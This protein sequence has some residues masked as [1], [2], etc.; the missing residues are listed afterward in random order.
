VHVLGP[1]CLDLVFSGLTAAPRPGAEV[2]ASQLGIAPGGMAN[3]AVALARLGA[4][5]GLSAVFADDPFG[6][7]LWAS[8]ADEGIDLTCSALVPGWNTPVT[9][10]VA[11]GRER[12]MVTYEED[13][14]VALRDLLPESYRAAALVVSLGA[15]DLGWLA[16]LHRFAPLVFAD[17]A[18]DEEARAPFAD[19]GARL[20]HVDVFLPNA[21]E[22]LA[23]T[24]ASS[25]A[26][27]AAQLAS[28]GP[29][30]VVKEGAA[31]S[32]AY[33]AG[34]DAPCSAPS[35]TVDARDT[36]GAGDIFDAGFVYG[37]LAE[38]PLAH[39]L[40]F[41][42]LCAAE[43]VKL[44][45]GSLAAP[46]WRD[47]AAFWRGLDDPVL[48]HDYRFLD[49]VMI[50]ARAGHDCRRSF[51]ALSGPVLARTGPGGVRG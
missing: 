49:D 18:L 8:L 3:V 33:S 2:F 23:L 30:V 32:L 5:V 21:A 11:V 41:A 45:G 28:H 9:S 42:N 39:R 4:D 27:A 12:G 16:G 6:Q 24:G 47:L 20:A 26:E 17:V 37:S 29:M 46:C 40:R 50:E 44:V 15:G 38:W 35:I 31:G 22:A 1:V 43:S 13:P 14:P 48:R 25:L 36:T 7:Y 19:L 51:P 34:M 10:S